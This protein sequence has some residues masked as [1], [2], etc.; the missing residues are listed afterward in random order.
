MTLSPATQKSL[1]KWHHM[2]ARRDLG[3]LPQIVAQGA[4]FRSPMAYPVYPGPDLVCLVLR[5]AMSV[6]ED[7]AYHREFVSGPSDVVLEFSARVGDKKLKGVDLIHF[8]EQG[9]ITEFEVMV[10]PA[11][12]LMALGQAMGARIGPIVSEAKNKG[13]KGGR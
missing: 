3:E 4:I 2:V 7:F 10:R 5:T 11:N 13:L 9:L 1:A 6:F 12:A 8:D